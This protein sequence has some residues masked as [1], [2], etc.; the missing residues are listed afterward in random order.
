MSFDDISSSFEE[1]L[2]SLA[3]A[4]H[5]DD[6]VDWG[7]GTLKE[8]DVVDIPVLNQAFL[9]EETQLGWND[10]LDKVGNFNV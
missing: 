9:I 6:D 5:D 1:K 4:N 8:E 10:E 7:D 2:Y 3:N